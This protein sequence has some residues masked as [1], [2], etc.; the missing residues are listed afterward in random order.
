MLDSESTQVIFEETKIGLWNWYN[1]KAR[2]R[3]RR[4]KENQSYQLHKEYED[5]DQTVKDLEDLKIYL[6]KLEHH[7]FVDD[8]HYY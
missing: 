4:R 5:F 3:R 1:R 7:Q 2:R 8:K 6:Y